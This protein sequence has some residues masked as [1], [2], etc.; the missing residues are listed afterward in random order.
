MKI[1]YIKNRRAPENQITRRILLTACGTALTLALTAL[2]PQLARAA[3]TAAPPDVPESIQVPPGNRLFRKGHAVGTQ[4]YICLST[5]WASSAYGPQATLFNEDNDQIIT[6]FLSP[7][8]DESNTPRPTW[9]DSRDTSTIW[10]NPIPDATYT[11]DS[12][13]I[14]WL[15]LEV[16]GAAEGPTGGDGMAGTTY[17]QRVNT[18]GGLK[19]TGSCTEGDKALVPYTADYFFYKDVL[20]LEG[21]T[22]VFTDARAFGLN[23]L[24]ATLTIGMFGD[25]AL[26]DD[27]STFR[28]DSNGVVAEGI[29]DL[30]EGDNPL[31]SDFSR[32]DFD[33]IFS[34]FTVAGLLIGDS[35]ETDCLVTEDDQELQ[36][37]NR[38]TGEI[39]TGQLQQ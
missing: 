8:P 22:F 7:N 39:S 9:Q 14:P 25:G 12:T 1:C 34:N 18:T 38:D 21:K 37:S 15:L 13:A 30:D 10:G 29:I 24:P 11:P 4:N 3:G 16:V 17:I 6:H 5:G 27:E 35:V 33:I 32:C 31:G 19:P 23:N 26:S 36:L 20:E 28:L 2:L